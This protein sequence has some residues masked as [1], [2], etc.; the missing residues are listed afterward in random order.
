MTDTGAVYALL[1][2]ALDLGDDVLD[3]DQRE[4]IDG[5]LAA[6]AGALGPEDRDEAPGARAALANI[7]TEDP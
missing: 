3:D 4:A 6:L 2:A 5:V 7:A 1:G